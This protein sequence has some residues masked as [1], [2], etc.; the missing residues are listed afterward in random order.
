MRRIEGSKLQAFYCGSNKQ[1][2]LMEVYGVTQGLD[3]SAYHVN[4]SLDI[5]RY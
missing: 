5:K 3:I 2:I 1:I 4:L